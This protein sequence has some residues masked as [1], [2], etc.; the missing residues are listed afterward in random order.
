MIK[1]GL[2]GWSLF[3]AV[4][5]VLGALGAWAKPSRSLASA[6]LVGSIAAM[7][8]TLGLF[9][10]GFEGLICIAIAA[11]LV[12]PLGAL[13]G[14]IIFQIEVTLVDSRRGSLML[15]LPLLTFAWDTHAKPEIFH[16]R[17]EVVIAATPEEVWR[18][19]VAF[20]PLPAPR[21]WY[22]RAGVSYPQRARIV[23][24]GVGATRY[25]E[26]S[27]GSFVE[28]IE[29]W[30]EPR[31][32]AFRVDA[33]PAPL[34]ELSPYGHIEPNHLHGYMISKHGEFRLTPLP[35]GRTLLAGTTWYQHGLWPA[36]YWKWWSDAIIHRIH[37][38]VL[39]HV[40][41]LAEQEHNHQNP[42]LTRRINK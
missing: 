28:P 26:F 38:R 4:P 30:D 1:S 41:E 8:P 39:D 3:V 22:F 11:P 20:S 29:T 34:N 36:Q 7:V 24:E 10:M 42:T 16:V 17:T 37:R 18:Q 6:A 31:L 13:G 2:Y 21:E 27:T 33:T 15:L 9:A 5:I 19:V 40:R 32:L 25:C 23:G 14:I 12:M 35:D